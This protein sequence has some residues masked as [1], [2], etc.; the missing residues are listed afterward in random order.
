MGRVKSDF[1][2]NYPQLLDYKLPQ[3]ELKEEIVA[4]I[5]DCWARL[6]LGYFEGL[7]RT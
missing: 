2:R 3:G 6:R 1:E 7:A 4:A 5:Q